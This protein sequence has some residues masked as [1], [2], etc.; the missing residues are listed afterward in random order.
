MLVS[1]VQQSDSAIRIYVSPLFW[2]SFPFRSPQSTEKVI[3]LS[4]SCSESSQPLKLRALLGA[5]LQGSGRGVC[6]GIW[7]RVCGWGKKPAL[8]EQ[9]PASR[10]ERFPRQSGMAGLSVLAGA[11]VQACGPS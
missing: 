4:S 7:K 9:K 2:I 8:E 11:F 1:T 3:T 6:L 10:M 5:G